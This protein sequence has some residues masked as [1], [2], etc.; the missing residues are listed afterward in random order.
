MR[1]AYRIFLDRDSYAA[2]FRVTTL[3]LPSSLRTVSAETTLLHAKKLAAVEGISR[4]TDTTRL[5]KIGIPVFASIRPAAKFGSLCV[6]AGKGL[7]P[8]DAQVGAFME[9]IEFSRAE[10]DRSHVE[11]V[12]AT[13][14]DVL[15]AA[16]RPEAILDFC[17]IARRSFD[18]A[19]DLACTEAYEVIGDRTTLVPAELVFLPYV[20]PRGTGN[21]GSTS[22][23]LASGNTL[24]EAFLH[25]LLE[26][27]ERDI[28]SFDELFPSSSVVRIK[29][30]PVELQEQ[31]ERITNAGLDIFI[32]ALASEFG[33]PCF[34]VGIL[35]R[36]A[37]SP[38]YFNGGYG[39]HTHRDIAIV[40]ALTEA[41]QSRLS[42]I[43]GG[44]DDL[45]GPF[46]D[47]AKIPAPLRA[48]IAIEQFEQHATEGSIAEYESLGDLS[49][50]A[51]TIQAATE[52]VIDSLLKNGIRH[53]CRVSLTLPDE[54]LQVVKVI[55][56]RLEQPY[57]GPRVGPRLRARVRRGR[58]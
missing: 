10:P 28:R 26:T 47:A 33:I 3:F 20:G 38:V 11:I 54:L 56:P 34:E 39:C 23:G 36:S 45:T 19:S 27:I 58:T 2:R 53:I 44:R 6:N 31:V 12:M 48:T 51:S 55:V 35:D 1:P 5:D 43:H 40:R 46:L 14:K 42:W 29:S 41:V 15:D 13:S 30:L 21:F 32:R 52:L 49:N 24:P 18:P 50:A 4:V 9:A 17:P 22:N 57:P 25:G 37:D 7:R 16:T 8:I